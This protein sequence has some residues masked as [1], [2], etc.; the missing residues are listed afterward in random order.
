M[1]RSR[2]KTSLRDVLWIIEWISTLADATV[3]QFGYDGLQ[4]KTYRSAKDT[5]GIVVSQYPFDSPD[6]LK[7]WLSSLSIKIK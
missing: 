6:E 5:A 4:R 7:K 1:D 2:D 3:K